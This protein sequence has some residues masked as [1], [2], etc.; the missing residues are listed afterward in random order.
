MRP[1]R[2]LLLGATVFVLLSAAGCQAPAPVSWH[3]LP[4]PDFVVRGSYNG[5]A[6]ARVDNA[7][8]IV[9]AS[10]EAPYGAIEIGNVD[11]FWPVDT[12]ADGRPAADW[13]DVEA[14]YTEAL[15][16][17]ALAG[18]VRDT[19]RSDAHA[20]RPIAVWS[21]ETTLFGTPDVLGVLYVPGYD[22]GPPAFV[23]PFSTLRSDA[24]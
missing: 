6:E 17:P 8:R 10:M 21:R 9:R 19:L 24:R 14:F 13:G 2:S 4:S 16:A 20:H 11:G 15:A 23:V 5:A 18:F 7:T 22:G 3:D 1:P 12:L